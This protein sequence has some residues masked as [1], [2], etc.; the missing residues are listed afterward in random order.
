M[1]KMFNFWRVCVILSASLFSLQ[2]CL[3]VDD[4]D[5]NL[6]ID[7]VEPPN[8]LVTVKPV[9]ENSFYMQLDDSTTLYPSNMK[10]SPFGNKEVRA[11]GRVVELNEPSK[12]YTKAVD[13]FWLDSILTKAT[14]PDLGVSN[15][16]VYGTDP[17]DIVKDWVSIAEDGYLTLLFRTNF[18]GNGTKHHVNLLT[19][20]NPENPY[21]VEFRHNAFGD[22]KGK[23]LNGLVAF[24]LDKLPDTKGKTVKL[25]LLWKSYDGTHSTEFD[26]CTRKS[27]KSI[28]AFSTF[29]LEPGM[30]ENIK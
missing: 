17:V 1:R 8:V 2:S 3:D 10:K 26:Y 4:N 16:S 9:G 7:P 12:G 18:S 27:T 29:P 14:A 22:L 11:L 21:E 20:Q 28:A 15:N 19:H 24:K 25:K 5:G 23:R 13:V 30:Y 6:V